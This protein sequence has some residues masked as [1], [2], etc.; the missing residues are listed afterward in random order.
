MAFVVQLTGFVEDF[1]CPCRP[2]A[3]LPEIVYTNIRLHP[4][5]H[6]IRDIV[7]GPAHGVSGP[8]VVASLVHMESCIRSSRLRGQSGEAKPTGCHLATA[9]P[10]E[11]MDGTMNTVFRF[12]K[13]YHRSQFEELAELFHDISYAGAHESAFPSSQRS[14]LSEVG[15][16]VWCGR[17]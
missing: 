8:G 1:V 17:R 12:N 4:R 3:T 14:Q 13:R 7:C 11:G 6:T 15:D 5:F 2:M 9:C 10:C 16:R